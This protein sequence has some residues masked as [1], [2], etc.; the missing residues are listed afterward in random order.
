M[1]KSELTETLAK[2]LN[3]PL[4]ISTGFVSTI[5]DSIT[6]TL[7][8]G[9]NVELRGFGSFSVKHYDS[10]INRNPKTGEKTVVKEK[11]LPCPSQKLVW[12]TKW[13]K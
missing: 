7:V 9:D 11:K 13:S 3:V 8:N 10:Y 2:E 4:Q 5:L 12:G 1:T 6:D